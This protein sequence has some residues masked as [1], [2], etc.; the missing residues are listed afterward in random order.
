M[1]VQSQGRGRILDV[2]EQGGGG[3]WKLDNFP[4]RHICVILYFMACFYFITNQQVWSIILPK[5]YPKVIEAKK[6]LHYDSKKK[7]Y[8]SKK[9][10]DFQSSIIKKVTAF[11]VRVVVQNVWEKITENLYFVKYL[12]RGSTEAA[13]RECSER[14]LFWNVLS[15]NFQKIFKTFFYR[16]ILDGFFCR[17]QSGV[18]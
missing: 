15:V 14:K 2:Y 18:F 3:S 6:W 17:K 4:R 5:F 12:T 10:R 16:I 7:K 8:F 1:D 13:V 9:F 11:K